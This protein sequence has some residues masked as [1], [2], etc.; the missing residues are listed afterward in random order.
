[1]LVAA[2]QRNAC[3]GNPRDL[4]FWF[5]QGSRKTETD[6]AVESWMTELVPRTW[7]VA[8]AKQEST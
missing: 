1:M 5:S 8:P 2:S 7:M 4:I 6:A 3:S